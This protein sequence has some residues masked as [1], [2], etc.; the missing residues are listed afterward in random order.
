MTKS[1]KS[2]IEAIP[3]AEIRLFHSQFSDLISQTRYFSTTLFH[4]LCNIILFD[5]HEISVIIT[6]A[7]KKN[8]FRAKGRIQI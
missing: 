5:R 8:N 4:S 3:L 1:E 6:A 7:A 2:L